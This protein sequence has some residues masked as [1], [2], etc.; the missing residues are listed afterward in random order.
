MMK[1]IVSITLVVIMVAALFVGCSTSVEGKYKLKTINDKEPKA[2]FT[3]MMTQMMTAFGMEGEELDK[4]VKEMNDSLD[5]LG[6][7][8]TIELKADGVME[9]KSEMDAAMDVGEEGEEGEE[10]KPESVTGTWK[11]DGETITLT[12]PGE[13]DEE[14]GEVKDTVLKGTLKDGKLTITEEPEEG[15]EDGMKMTMVL[16]K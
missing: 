15:E 3:E 9:M 11:Q 4:A 12:Y 5:K 14:T 7:L 6:D 8:L 1:R 13:K 10:S 16:A 2:F